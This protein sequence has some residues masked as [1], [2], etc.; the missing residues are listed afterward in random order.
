ML[1]ASKKAKMLNALKA[2]KKKFLD[3]N[4]SE[5]DESG[6]RLMINH[7]LSDVLGFLPIE[8]IKTEY[9]IKGTYA[10][11]VV[12]TKG[13]RNFLVE[14]K[15]LSY[16][17]SDKHL[18]QTIN[19]GANEGIEWALLTNGRNF[20]FYKIL[21]NKPIESRKIFSVDLSD[22]ST[23]KSSI[24]QLQ[25][26]HKEAITKKSLK[27]LWN[28]CE[29]LFPEHVAGIIYS[30]EVIGTIKRLIKAKYGEKCDDEDILKTLERIVCEKFDPATIKPYRAV[31]SD[32][33]PKKLKE[34]EA[35]QISNSEIIEKVEDI[36][37]ES[38]N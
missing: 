30:K 1:T 5:L 29:A 22:A 14:V 35:K 24:E 3:L 34:N 33:R 37:P 12:Q 21:F 32:K 31:R 4:L 25:Y 11:Y 7:F 13:I 8:E 16:D 20:E 6:T 27:V 23:F 2:Y 15:A 28:K 10:D 19:Y 9:M 18:R 36:Q 26:L 17:L 38:L